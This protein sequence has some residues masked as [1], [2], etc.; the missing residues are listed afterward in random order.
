MPALI[1][2]LTDGPSDAARTNSPAAN[3][4][5]P[6]TRK[7]TTTTLTALKAHATPAVFVTAYDY[8]TAGFADRAGADMLLV[9]DSASDGW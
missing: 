4:V 7:V 8:P 5:T 2:P 9:G 3:G 6:S 1:A